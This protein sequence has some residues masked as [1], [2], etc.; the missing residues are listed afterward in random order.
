M[1]NNKHNITTLVFVDPAIINTKLDQDEDVVN[2]EEKRGFFGG[3]FST[4]TSIFSS[5]DRSIGDMVHDIARNNTVIEIDITDPEFHKF[6]DMYNV[7]TYPF[8]IV[9]KG[10]KILYRSNITRNTDEKVESI[11]GAY[12]DDLQGK[13]EGVQTNTFEEVYTTQG[14]KKVLKEDIVTIAPGNSTFKSSSFDDPFYF[15]NSTMNRTVD[16][17]VQEVVY[18]NVTPVV[19]VVEQ[20]APSYSQQ[21]ISYDPNAPYAPVHGY[22]PTAPRRSHNRYAAPGTMNRTTSNS[23]FSRSYPRVQRNLPESKNSTE[24]V[25]EEVIQENLPR[26]T[27]VTSTTRYHSTPFGYEAN[28]DA[29]SNAGERWKQILEEEERMVDEI[30]NIYKDDANLSKTLQESED[31][32]HES[33]ELFY[34]AKNEIDRTLMESEKQMIQYEQE[35]DKLYRAR[36]A[37]IQAREDLYHPCINCAPTKEGFIRQRIAGPYQSVKRATTATPEQ[38]YFHEMYDRLANRTTTANPK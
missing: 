21:Y 24:I 32:I 13:N 27:E 3:F 34:K 6:E 22:V 16:Y 36:Q 15:N 23:S 18:T 26:R 11:L 9:L 7:Q 33:E 31:E 38:Y 2:K 12:Y 8:I 35:L 4:V 17:A 10:N 29:Y 30:A 37:A 20:V 25:V 5:S 19:S 28:E 14:P 1:D